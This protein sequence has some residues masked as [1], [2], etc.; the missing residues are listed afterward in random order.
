[1]FARDITLDKFTNFAATRDITGTKPIGWIERVRWENS[2]PTPTRGLIIDTYCLGS[3][4]IVEHPWTT[5]HSIP[6]NKDT[7]EAPVRMLMKS[8]TQAIFGPHSTDPAGMCPLSPFE[9]LFHQMG[10]YNLYVFGTAS[11]KD[12]LGGIEVHRTDFCVGVKITGNMEK[13]Y[14]DA[15][16]VPSLTGTAY[17]CAEHNCADAEREREDKEDAARGRAEAHGNPK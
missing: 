10:F 12:V 13:G 7:P 11:Y 4:D 17:K 3:F 9:V 1:M 6:F 2:G 16:G 15:A 5:R 8:Q 14:A